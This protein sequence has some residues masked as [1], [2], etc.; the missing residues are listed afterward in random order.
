VDADYDPID[1]TGTSLVTTDRRDLEGYTLSVECF[2]KVVSVGLATDEPTADS[3]LEMVLTESRKMAILRLVSREQSWNMPFRKTALYPAVR[4]SRRSLSLDLRQA[5][6]RLAG[7]SIGFDRLAEV[8]ER[9]GEMSARMSGTDDLELI[10]G[11]DATQIAAELLIKH[12]VA[13]ADA[14]RLLRM[15]FE[16]DMARSY[17]NLAELIDFLCAA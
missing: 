13:R 7:K 15:S 3:F 12:G 6:G 16:R 5:A 17:P 10:H 14:T 2:L 1:T 8:L 4:A 11:K 9:H